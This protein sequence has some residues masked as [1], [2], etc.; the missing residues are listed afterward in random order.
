MRCWSPSFSDLSDLSSSLSATIS[1]ILACSQSLVVLINSLSSRCG[2]VR[3]VAQSNSKNKKEI[4]RWRR[5]Q[6]ES[7]VEEETKEFG[8]CNDNELK[9]IQ[10]RRQ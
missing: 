10:T 9:Y 2:G 7:I 4:K 3:C 5:K 8:R 6:C 1:L